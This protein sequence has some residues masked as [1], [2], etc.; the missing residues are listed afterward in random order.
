MKLSLNQ[1]KRDK[2]SSEGRPHITLKGQK[3]SALGF[4]C[5]RLYGNAS[6][7]NLRKLRLSL[8]KGLDKKAM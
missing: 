7:E 6:P 4:T 2:A 8:S 3:K 1:Y 5:Y